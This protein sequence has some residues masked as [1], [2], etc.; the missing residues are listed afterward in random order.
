M[1]FLKWSKREII[2]LKRLSIVGYSLLT[3]I[4]AV[5]ISTVCYEPVVTELRSQAEE[6]LNRIYHLE[7]RLVEVDE[8]KNTTL[9]DSVYQ[10]LLS[11]RANFPEIT[12]RQFQIESANFTSNI[13]R[14]A[15]NLCG[16]KFPTTRPTTAIGSHTSR[17]SCKYAKYGNWK[18]CILDF[19]IWQSLNT[20]GLTEKEYI[21]YLEKH[22]AEDQDYAKKIS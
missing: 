17:D 9:K 11:I 22:Y 21:Q 20:K 19:V 14:E 18:E 6:R 1:N 12:L 16:M 5:V 2:R 13:F 3:F 10:Y 15:N 4:I 7:A 8:V